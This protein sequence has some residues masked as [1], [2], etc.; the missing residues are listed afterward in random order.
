MERIEV[1]YKPV[2]LNFPY[3]HK[4]IICICNDGSVYYARGG[5]LS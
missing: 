4:F 1:R 3:Y 2:P 5:I